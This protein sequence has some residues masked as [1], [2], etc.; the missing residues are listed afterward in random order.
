MDNTKKLKK[1]SASSL[2]VMSQSPTGVGRAIFKAFKYRIYPTEAQKVLIEKHIGACRFIY[3][4]AL[5]TKIT[6]Y[7]SNRVNT[8]FYSLCA[9]LPELKK[10]CEWLKE[11]GAQ[12]LQNSIMNMDGS[13]KKFFK[14]QTDFPKFKKK[15][16]GG[17]FQCPQ[18]ANIEDSNLWLPKF[19]EAI[20]IVVSR[21]YIGKIKTCTVS[22]TATGKYFVSVLCDT[23]IKEPTKKPIKEK[24][25]V[26]VDLGIKTFA[27]TS[28]GLEIESPKFLRKSE[29]KLKYLQRKAQIHVLL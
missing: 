25:T 18:K 5:E 7:E 24:T 3:N 28:S 6:A 15:S 20:K 10:E 2:T 8:S 19:K 27:V 29:S 13:F 1:N 4:L 12:S 21:P 26:G 14:G 9:Q 11:I 17:S 22:K 16:N 23:G